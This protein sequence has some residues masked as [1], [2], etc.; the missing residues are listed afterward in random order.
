MHVDYKVT[1]WRREEFDD[2][3]ITADEL[4]EEIKNHGFCEKGFVENDILYETEEQITPLENG[5]N[6]TI[7]IFSGNKLLWDNNEQEE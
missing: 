6:P 5:N 7:E 3:E 1:I 4:I 2:D